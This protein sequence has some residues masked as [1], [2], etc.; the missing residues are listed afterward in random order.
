MGKTTYQELRDVWGINIGPMGTA[1]AFANNGVEVPEHPNT[2]AGNNP[3]GYVDPSGSKWVNPNDPRW[4]KR[5]DYPSSAWN[6]FYCHIAPYLPCIQ[7]TVS[8]TYAILA[9]HPGLPGDQGGPK[10]A[11]RHCVWACLTRKT[12][13]KEAYQ[14]GVIDHENS[15]APWAKGKWNPTYSPQDLANDEMG[16][17]MSRRSGSCEAECV[18]ALKRGDLYILPKKNWQG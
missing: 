5:P 8:S 3:I 6:A 10:D 13:G 4:P 17:A 14:H 11:L 18:A 2:Y 1:E 7:R 9:R 16:D 15:T 12:C